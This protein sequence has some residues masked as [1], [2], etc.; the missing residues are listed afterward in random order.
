MRI[1]KEKRKVV[2]Y[3]KENGFKVDKRLTKKH[4]KLNNE[5]LFYLTKDRF[6]IFKLIWDSD[7][8]FKNSELIDFGI[9][10][11]DEGTRNFIKFK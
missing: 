10:H 7:Y 1:N 8:N 11:L 2:C 4:F 6:E 3:L 5:I 9:V